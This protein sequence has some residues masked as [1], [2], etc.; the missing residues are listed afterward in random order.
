MINLLKL[1]PIWKTVL[2]SWLSKKL[3][4]LLDKLRPAEG[5]LHM[6]GRVPAFLDDYAHLVDGLISLYE[7][8]FEERWLAAAIELADEMLARFDDPASPLLYD[9]SDRH[10]A[11]LS[12]PREMQ[13]GATPCGNSVAAGALVRLAI[14][15]GRTDL[16]TRAGEML[17]VLADPMA[18]QPVG[19]GRFLAALDAWLAMSREVVIAGAPAD[20]AVADLAHAF[21]IRYEPNAVLALAPDG[22][23]SPLIPITEHRPLRDG[24]ATAY[25][26]EAYSCLPPATDPA[27]LAVRLEIGSG[28]TW[29]EF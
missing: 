25:V 26:C 2:K 14:L 7:A 24:K 15:T 8:S 9:T 20:P 22:E 3:T 18:E 13:D 5:L 27:E 11:L 6:D 16:R 28:V 12:R 17:K 10:E 29:Q 23:A 4:W 21:A 1:P 19:F